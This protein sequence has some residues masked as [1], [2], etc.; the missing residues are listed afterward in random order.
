M[1]LLLSLALPILASAPTVPTFLVGDK[2]LLDD[3]MT[4]ACVTRVV[5]ATNTY[6]IQRYTA[7]RTPSGATERMVATESHALLARCDFFILAF[8]N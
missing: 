5:L 1:K 8:L 2:I 7:A 4:T 3:G 6:R